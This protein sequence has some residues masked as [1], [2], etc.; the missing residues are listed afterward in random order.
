MV[1]KEFDIE[2]YELEPQGPVCCN[3]AFCRR[4]FVEENGHGY[5]CELHRRLVALS[6]FEY[7]Y[8]FGILCIY[9]TSCKHFTSQTAL[10]ELDAEDSLEKIEIMQSLGKF[11]KIPPII[12]EMRKNWFLDR[13]DATQNQFEYSA[14][15]SRKH[16][17]FVPAK[18]DGHE[19]GCIRITRCADKQILRSWIGKLMPSLKTQM[20]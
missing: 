14:Y 19:Y 13:G 20:M 18:I 4:R 12:V 7:S 1:E 15:L 3:C 8:Q 11:E 2:T 6:G 17:R 16:K 5:Y 10:E 9:T